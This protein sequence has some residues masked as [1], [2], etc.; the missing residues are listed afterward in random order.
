MKILL[1][2]A[3]GQLGIELRASLRGLG[4]VV[5]VTPDGVLPNGETGEVVDFEYVAALAPLI[6]RVAPDLVVNAAAYTAV[7]QAE[8]APDVAFRVNAEAPGAIAAACAARGIRL[9]HYSTD[10]VFAGDARRPYAEDDAPAPVNVYGASK[11]AGERAIQSADP[12][13]LIV[14]TSGLY[15]EHSGNFLTTMLRLAR[16][17]DEIRVVDD[18]TGTPTS[19]RT[20]ASTTARLLAGP[21]PIDGIWHLAA[22]GGV[23]WHAFAVAIFEQAFARGLIS[24]IPR[25]VAIASAE[26]AARAR[27]P[28][29]SA[30]DSRRLRNVYD[31]ALPDWRDDLAATLARFDP[32]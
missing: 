22:Q 14:R 13:H 31:V 3:N 8:D 12:R 28:A 5:P 23:T 7:D 21:A 26:F 19:A 11:L 30:L 27:R 2:G 9:V 4:E 29:Y 15:A 18:Q 6:A 1:F 20:V 32:Q 17:R 10:Y 16:E 25:T 24:R